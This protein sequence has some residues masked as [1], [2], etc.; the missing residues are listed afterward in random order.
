MGCAKFLDMLSD[1]IDGALA[2]E[3]REYLLTHLD[4][5]LHCASI[6]YDLDLIVRLARELRN[7]LAITPASIKSA[8]FTGGFYRPTIAM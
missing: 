4:A 1:L 5:C 8:V 6:K 7:E 2:P 3:D